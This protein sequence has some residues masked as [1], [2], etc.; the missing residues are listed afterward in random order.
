MLMLVMAGTQKQSSQPSTD[1]VSEATSNSASHSTSVGSAL[2][3]GL[4]TPDQGRGSLSN[5][6]DHDGNPDSMV[7]PGVGF[8]VYFVVLP[9]LAAV[10]CLRLCEPLILRGLGYRLA[11]EHPG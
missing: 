7:D 4:E 3:S 1:I 6:K 10:H 9:F 5:D 8:C 2:A 11:L